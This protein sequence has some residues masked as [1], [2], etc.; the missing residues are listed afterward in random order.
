MTMMMLKRCLHLWIIQ[1][2]GCLTFSTYLWK[3]W[4]KQT[5]TKDC[6][7][8]INHT[9][10]SQII[11]PFSSF[12]NH[13]YFIRI[14]FWIYIEF[15]HKT[16]HIYL[17]LDKIKLN[18]FVRYFYLCTEF[19]LRGK[20]SIYLDWFWRILCNHIWNENAGF[21]CLW[22]FILFSN[23]RRNICLNVNGNS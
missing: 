7:S 23:K 8:T 19:T 2:Y 17:W 18:F 1:F 22:S 5:W 20:I 6:C 10:F 13:F 14:W 15:T 16:I 4:K 21:Y 3:L 12:L 11:V 9:I